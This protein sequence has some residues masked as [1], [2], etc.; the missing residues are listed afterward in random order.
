MTLLK[1]IIV[2]SIILNIALLVSLVEPP[3]VIDIPVE[4]SGKSSIKN[5]KYSCN[6]Y[7]IYVHSD[8]VKHPHY[9]YCS[10]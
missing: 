6:K 1:I 8:G 7:T 2:I 4:D 10:I 9:R 5:S 3:A